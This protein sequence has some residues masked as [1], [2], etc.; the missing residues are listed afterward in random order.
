M[1]PRPLIN[2]DSTQHL[3]QVLIIHRLDVAA[4][5]IQ[6]AQIIR[7]I[8]P[9]EFPRLEPIPQKCK[10]IRIP[11]VNLKILIPWRLQELQEMQA[12]ARVYDHLSVLPPLLKP[13]PTRARPR[14]PLQEQ[15]RV[16]AELAA[17]VQPRGVGLDI[18]DL[19]LLDG[20]EH[21][22]RPALDQRHEA[23]VAER[24]VRPAEAEVVGEARHA[25]GQVRRHAVVGA[26]EVAEVDAVAADEGEA[27]DPGGVEARG[28]D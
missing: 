3:N 17:E 20:V 11:I 7:N 28:A 5:V 21:V 8:P 18:L 27:W 12:A 19:G 26:P 4:L 15:I 25:D 24:A 6:G 14:R 9:I 13:A 23:A 10:P 16:G 2:I 22:A 1:L